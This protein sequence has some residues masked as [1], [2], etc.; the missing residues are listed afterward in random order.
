MMTMTIVMLMCGEN[1][2]EFVCRE[3]VF[4]HPIHGGNVGAGVRGRGSKRA[5]V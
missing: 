4:I 1:R 2:V 3:H 5:Y